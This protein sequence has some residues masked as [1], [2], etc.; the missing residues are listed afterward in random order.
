MGVGPHSTDTHMGLAPQNLTN[1][2]TNL[3]DLLGHQ[4][5]PTFWPFTDHT[6]P[7]RNTVFNTS[8]SSVLFDFSPNAVLFIS[9]II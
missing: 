3:A 1:K 4:I 9:L 8:Y 2:L 5:F 7:R 6:Q